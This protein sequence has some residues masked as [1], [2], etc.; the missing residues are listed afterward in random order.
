[1]A[2]RDQPESLFFKPHGK[3]V[4]LALVYYF[5]IST[6][7]LRL[8]WIPIGFIAHGQICHAKS[9]FR[10]TN[11]P[12]QCCSV[13]APIYPRCSQPSECCG[14]AVRISWRNNRIHLRERGN[15]TV[16]DDDLGSEC[17]SPDDH[18]FVE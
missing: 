12:R 4:S 17:K 8:C 11:P 7:G 15:Q 1:M 16:A 5:Q 13:L 2:R 10:S 14:I 6:A 9:Q 3:E 18:E